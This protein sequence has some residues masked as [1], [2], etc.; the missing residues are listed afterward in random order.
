MKKLTLALTAASLTASLS[1]LASVPTGAQPFQ[2]IVP[3][4]KSGMELTVAGLYLQPTNSDL[5]YETLIAGTDGA[6]NTNVEN[7]NPNY[8]WGIR[9][10]VGYIFPDTGNDV[11]A[12]WTH[13][14]QSSTDST[15]YMLD[16]SGTSFITSRAG[17]VYRI[18]GD[19]E[20]SLGASSNAEF[21]YD[22]IDLDVGQYL[23]IGTRLQ[24]R[25]FAGVRFAQIKNN[26]TDDYNYEVPE[27]L[28]SIN[29]TDYFQSQFTGI[30]PRF[31]VDMS[32]N[33][34]NCFGLVGS[35]AGALLVGREQAS[36]N[37]DLLVSTV[38]VPL[39]A[40]A[41]TDNT[42]RI[43]P[44]FDAKLGVDYSI[45]FKNDAARLSIEAGY[46]V[47]QYIDAIDRLDSNLGAVLAEGAIPTAVTRTTSDIGFSGPYLSLNLKV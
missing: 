45:P 41:N 44:S 39:T 32:Y 27:A 23:S 24:T 11:Q 43:V 3:N 33:V 37:V 29:E 15:N 18:L 2:I 5:N 42:T 40:T 21:Q 22:A 30:G 4:L 12:N 13:L 9:V 47:T 35:V 25:L 16:S 46:Q 31:G 6:A 7:V 14:T 19:G 36:T 28:F 10:G 20:S 8:G 26:I 34:W 38:P 1:A 17:T